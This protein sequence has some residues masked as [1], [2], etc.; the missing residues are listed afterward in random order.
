MNFYDLLRHYIK[1][2]DIKH[3]VLATRLGVSPNYITNIL[4]KRTSS[5]TFEMTEKLADIFNLPPGSKERTDFFQACW[6]SKFSEGDKKF[7]ALLGF[8]S[9]QDSQLL[10]KEGSSHLF[11]QSLLEEELR[12]FLNEYYELSKNNKE[13]FLKKIKGFF[14]E[15]K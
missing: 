10:N 7:V 14:E 2:N 12:G 11:E 5:P 1:K 6:V 15:I 9:V 13:L 3:V 4:S 8:I